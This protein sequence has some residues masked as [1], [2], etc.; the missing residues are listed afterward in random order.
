MKSERWIHPGWLLGAVLFG[1]VGVVRAAGL[2]VWEYPGLIVRIVSVSSTSVF[3]VGFVML[4]TRSYKIIRDKKR[5]K[6]KHWMVF[7]MFPYVAAFYYPFQED[8]SDDF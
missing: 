5:E 1:L 8:F 6:A 7:F 2:F 3:V 4:L